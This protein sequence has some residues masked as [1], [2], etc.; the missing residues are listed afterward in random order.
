MGVNSL[1]KTV[2]RQCRD[3][4]LNPRPFAPESSTLTGCSVSTFG[5]SCL[6]TCRSTPAVSQEK[7]TCTFVWMQ[8]ADVAIAALLLLF[9]ACSLTCTDGCDTALWVNWYIAIGCFGLT[10]DHG[11]TRS[12]AWPSD[13]QWDA[14]RHIHFD[15][16]WVWYANVATDNVAINCT[17]E[18]LPTD[19]SVEGCLKWHMTTLMKR[20]VWLTAL[21][22]RLGYFWYRIFAQN[23]SW[24]R[25]AE[26]PALTTAH[27]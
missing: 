23:R 1:P 21:K 22:V 11:F 7:R 6:H 12:C 14:R 3:C 25:R 20:R 10:G 5:G 19:V 4:D 8:Y 13:R 26:Y 24:T 2:T 27:S 17:G 15:I 16:W 18:F 9:T